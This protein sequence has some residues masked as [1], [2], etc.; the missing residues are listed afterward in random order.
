M[1]E[2][3]ILRPDRLRQVPPQFSWVDH[4]LV[5]QNRLRDCDVS[6]WALYLFLVTVADAHGL[7]YYSDA[8]LCRQLRLDAPS[9]ATARR[10]L[11]AAELIA[12]Q[13][14]LC[15]VLALVERLTNTPST[16]AAGTRSIGDILRQA[17]GGA[18]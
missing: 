3:R 4:R 7:S 6:A 9:L 15:Q 14:P 13:K 8:S 5:R 1:T 18:S 11:I 16:P 17:L 12:Y 10:Q 2:K